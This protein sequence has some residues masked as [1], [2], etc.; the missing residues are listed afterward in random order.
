MDW[1]MVV[2]EPKCTD[3]LASQFPREFV[4]M[5]DPYTGRITKDSLQN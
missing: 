2:F 1:P 4:Q 5:L 3:R